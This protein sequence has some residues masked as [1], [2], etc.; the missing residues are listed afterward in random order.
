MNAI[1]RRRLVAPTP[2]L[3]TRNLSSLE[4]NPQNARKHSDKQLGQLTAAVLKFGFFNPVLID[5]RNAIIAGHGRYEAAKRLGYAQVPCFVISGLSQHERIALALADNKIPMNA[6][7]DMVSLREELQIIADPS[8]S[9]DV[10]YSGFDTVEIDNIILPPIVHDDNEEEIPLPQA[11][12]VTHIGDTWELGQHRII[13]GDSRKPETFAALM[14]SERARMVF[15]DPPYNVRIHGHVSGLGR[16]RHREFEM[17]TGEMTT[18]QFRTFLTDTLKLPAGYCQA[19]AILFS[20]MDWRHM[21][22]MVQAGEG[23]NLELKNVIVWAKNNGGMGTFYRSAHELIFAFKKDGAAHVNNFGLGEHGRYRTN[24]WEYP[25]ANTFRRGRSTEL[26][27]HPTPKPVALVADTIR[28]VSHIQ[29]IVID[30]FGGSGS[31]L[32][33]AERTKRRARLVELDPLY[34]DV[35]LRR[36]EALTGDRAVHQDT[37]RTFSQIAAERE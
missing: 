25:G 8:S 10:S 34:V 14:G 17:A 35:T 37:Q 9:I 20:C 29:D 18:Q 24:V 27:A 2:Q 11:T 28:D 4:K 15:Q 22:D 23:A 12:P 6:E 1:P 31:T 30:S 19:G 32:I 33:A 26:A 36:W 21:T 13:C 7:W 3:V 16:T 5:D